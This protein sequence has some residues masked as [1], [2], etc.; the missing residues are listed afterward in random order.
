MD[1]LTPESHGNIISVSSS[2]FETFQL[3]EPPEEPKRRPE[4]GTHGPGN[5]IQ[6]PS[7]GAANPSSNRHCEEC[8]ARLSQAP[9]PT[10]PRPAV[11]ATAG[12]R[13]ALAIS[14]LLFGVVI[15]ALAFNVLGGDDTPTST[16]VAATSTTAP[17]V[18]ENGPIPVISESCSAEGISSFVCANLTSGTEDS[19]Q[20]NW[21]ELQ[22]EGGIITIRLTFDQPMIVQQIIWR[23]LTDP[24]RFQQ[25]Y[26]PRGLIITASDQ[27]TDFAHQLEDVPGEQVFP[28][29]A[30][31]ANWVEFEVTSEF[32]A[33]LTEGN[34][35]RDMAIDEITIIGRPQ[36]AATNTTAT[37][38]TTAP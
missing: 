15:V 31:G 16:T 32:A 25:N 26:R 19:Y 3:R 37:T 35:F 9:L 23:N 30:V 17:T 34:V 21:E 1:P 14:G 10:A 2:G 11:Q 36:A 5:S 13:A 29:A 24:V 33:T 7:C 12:V 22:A 20:V 18:E 38:T 8:G 4:R 27:V 28:Y 6:C